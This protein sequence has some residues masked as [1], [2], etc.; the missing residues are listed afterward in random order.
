[1]AESGQGVKI[2]QLE[3]SPALN[4]SDYTVIVHSGTT[5]KT[6]LNS[7]QKYFNQDAADTVVQVESLKDRVSTVENKA[8]SN[9]GSIAMINKSIDEKYNEVTIAVET[10]R[11]NISFLS[12]SIE[13][14]S[15]NVSSTVNLLSILIENPGLIEMLSALSGGEML[16]DSII[17]IKQ[18]LNN[19]SGAIDEALTSIY[20]VEDDTD[21]VRSYADEIFNNTLILDST[22]L[23]NEYYN[24]SFNPIIV[25][26]DN[27]NEDYE[28]KDIYCFGNSLLISGNT[29]YLSVNEEDGSLL[30]VRKNGSSTSIVDPPGKATFNINAIPIRGGMF[31]EDNGESHL[32]LI[33]RGDSNVAIYLTNSRIRNVDSILSVEINNT[34]LKSRSNVAAQGIDS[35]LKLFW[36]GDIESNGKIYF[37]A[38]GTDLCANNL[39]GAIVPRLKASEVSELDVSLERIE[40]DSNDLNST[41]T[42]FVGVNGGYNGQEVPL[43]VEIIKTDE[44]LASLTSNVFLNSFPRISWNNQA[45]IAPTGITFNQIDSI[46]I[47]AYDDVRDSI[48]ST[49]VDHDMLNGLTSIIDQ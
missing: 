13:T 33:V 3:T 1:M 9:A 32:N 18:D 41:F 6:D 16:S 35:D 2:S 21:Y 27:F 28:N 36:S 38:S 46:S 11:N 49:F 30:S 8:N 40:L 45:S 44:T 26:L 48:A 47:S 24:N 29:T 34:L 14:V 10:N 37:R 42:L 25:D 4:R 5:Y 31:M 12:D 15:S 22:C 39:I 23:I 20:K 43:S 19:I 17:Q 7:I